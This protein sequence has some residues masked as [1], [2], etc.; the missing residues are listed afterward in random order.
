MVKEGASKIAGDAAGMAELFKGQAS[1]VIQALRPQSQAPSSFGNSYT[2]ND[3]SNLQE[4]PLSEDSIYQAA[5]NAVHESKSS[6]L[7]TT[8]PQLASKTFT[9]AN[10]MS[11]SQSSD[12]TLKSTPS[13]NISSHSEPSRLHKDPDLIEVAQTA[14]SQSSQEVIKTA[15]TSGGSMSQPQ[16]SSSLNQQR[17]TTQS[18][19]TTQKKKMLPPKQSVSIIVYCSILYQ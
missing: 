18:F 17:P 7:H 19:S 15:S 4:E 13:Q 9:D 14:S 12:S 16:V 1:A 3:F 8:E 11:K 10:S 5:A 6:H 2:T